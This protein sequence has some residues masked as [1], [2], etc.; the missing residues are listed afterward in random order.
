MNCRISANI[1]LTKCQQLRAA[2]NLECRGCT[3]KP[4]RTIV[5]ELPADVYEAI[6]S[7]VEGRQGGVEEWILDVLSLAATG[8]YV[9][10]KVSA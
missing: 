5:L 10:A 1:G 9:L 8:R 3:S 4:T 7:D 2:N 6:Q